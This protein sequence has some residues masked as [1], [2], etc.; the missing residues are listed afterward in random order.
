[1]TRTKPK[2]F[3]GKRVVVVGLGNS[4]AD[5]S[6]SLVGY[7]KVVYVSHRAGAY[8]VRPVPS[9]VPTPLHTKP[10]IVLTESRSRGT[11]MASHSIMR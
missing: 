10:A 1:M 6:T 5:I 4:G 8:I 7:A 11:S 9:P 2:R 3:E